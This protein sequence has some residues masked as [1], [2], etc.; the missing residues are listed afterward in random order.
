[1]RRR[2]LDF[3]GCFCY[4]INEMTEKQTP[5]YHADT[6]VDLTTD[7]GVQLQAELEKTGEMPE[8]L[9]RKIGATAL[10][11]SYILVRLPGGDDKTVH[12]WM[13]IGKGD[14]GT[15]VRNS[16]RE[17]E[18]QAPEQRLG[19]PSAEA[20]AYDIMSAD[21]PGKQN[22]EAAR[23]GQRGAAIE[24][25]EAFADDLVKRAT[26]LKMN[27]T[28]A[29][30][31]H[32]PGE[33]ARE[34]VTEDSINEANSRIEQLAKS[35]GDFAA[36]MNAYYDERFGEEPLDQLRL[37]TDLRAALLKYFER[38]IDNYPQ[39]DELPERVRLNDPDNLKAI[40]HSGY[41]VEKATSGQYVAMLM[42]SMLD[43]SFDA[44]IEDRVHS[45]DR[46]DG[47]PGHGMHRDAARMML[48]Y[49]IDRK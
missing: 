45:H 24:R 31:N 48:K 32:F 25:Q 42:L 33:W 8:Q 21:V 41:P 38:E 6:I 7:S 36:H 26:P 15:I 49:L 34:R 9:A 3:F 29:L 11:A 40:N 20:V 35:K 28:E 17:G 14:M 46:H 1:M 44:R 27:S 12:R 30:H 22:D 13:N 18:E 23:V 5:K 2:R 10:E 37:N 39:R 16:I 19:L 4:N 47:T 43:A